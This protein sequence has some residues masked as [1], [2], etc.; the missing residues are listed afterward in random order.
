MTVFVEKM[1]KHEKKYSLMKIL[2]YFKQLFLDLVR[3]QVSSTK[4][5]VKMLNSS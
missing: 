5:S 3:F 2:K 4:C 1:K